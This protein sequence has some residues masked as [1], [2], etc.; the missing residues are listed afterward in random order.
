VETTHNTE[1]VA[2]GRE[3]KRQSFVEVT[4]DGNPMKI[5]RGHYVVSDLKEALGVSPDY[6][7]DQV[8]DGEFKPLDDTAKI[9]IKGD[10]VFVSHVRR[11]GA[12]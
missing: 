7:L 1:G 12:S 3:D 4:I 2:E 6:E 5:H 10:E 9:V 8:I 11:G